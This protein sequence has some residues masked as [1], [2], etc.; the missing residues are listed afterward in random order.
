MNR[1]IFLAGLLGTV[2]LPGYSR[3]ETLHTKLIGFQEVPSVSTPARGEF[4]VKISKDEDSIEYELTYEGL[5]GNVTQAHIHFAQR[6]VNGS[7]V[8]WLCTTDLI[9]PQTAPAGTQ[10][11][12]ASPAT[13]TGTITAAN[14]IAASNTAQQI[15]AG[16]LAEVIAAMRAGK[17]YVN[18]HTTLS[19][20][21]EIRGQL[22]DGHK[23][24][25]KDKHHDKR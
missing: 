21:G 16:E 25:D 14:V 8:I 3:A 17:T 5:Q 22:R 11:C 15:V 4:R 18:V 7:I 19:S 1:L 2:A 20:G 13:I 9:V 12:P 10:T 24:K 23:G 6:G